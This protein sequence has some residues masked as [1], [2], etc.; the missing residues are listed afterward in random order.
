MA[1]DREGSDYFHSPLIPQGGKTRER[2]NKLLVFFYPLLKTV[3]VHRMRHMPNVLVM[4]V[5]G[6]K[7][8]IAKKPIKYPIFYECNGLYYRYL[9]LE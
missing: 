3:Y 4:I 7:R 5:F 1:L 2:I 9:K 6:V 8:G